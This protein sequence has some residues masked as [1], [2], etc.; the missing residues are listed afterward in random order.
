VNKVLITGSYGFIASNIIDK[1]NLRS[2]VRIFSIGTNTKK[3]NKKFN[4]YKHLES[5]I[6]LENL[7]IL[8]DSTPDV[9]LHCAGVGTVNQAS[10]SYLSNESTLYTSKEVCKF[11]KKHKVKKVIFL[12]S[13]AVYGNTFDDKKYKIKPI[14]NYGKLKIKC[15]KMF[16]SLDGTT[17]ITLRLFSVYGP[18]MKKQLIYD[19]FENFLHKKKP[20]FRGTGDQIRD[21]IHI[22]DVINVIEYFIFE[23]KSRDNIIQDVGTGVGTKIKSLIEMISMEYFKHS[24]YKKGFDFDNKSLS[25]D[26][27]VLIANNDQVYYSPIKFIKINDGVIEYAREFYNQ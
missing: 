25:N 1:L 24:K 13:A 26:P 21:F 17:S 2:D 7:E 4:T 16:Q 12:S 10:S 8:C 20:I 14:S 5:K 3:L 9:I 27:K 19:A 6:N 23:N 11:A 22:I 15:E 18:N